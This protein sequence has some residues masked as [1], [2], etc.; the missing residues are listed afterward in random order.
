MRIDESLH[1]LEVKA[2]GDGFLGIAALRGD[3]GSVALFDAGLPGSL[4]SLRACL[5]E[6]GL[7]FEAV[8]RVFVTHH[9]FD[10]IG[11]IPELL[12]AAV[13]RKVLV[14]AHAEEV[15]YVQGERPPVKTEPAVRA[16][17]QANLPE[18]Q[19]LGAP[20]P[21]QDPPRIPVGTVLADGQHLDFAGGI[22][23]I[24]VPGHTPGHLCYYLHRSRVLVAGD[25]LLSD[26]G[27]LTP[28]T[29]IHSADIRRAYASLRKLD[30]FDIAAVVCYHGGYVAD[31]IRAQLR[32]LPA[33]YE[34]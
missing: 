23:A 26:G 6:A 15:P 8:D 24:H 5:E 28:P 22:T 2:W 1:M 21:L 30:A 10:H 3:D 32:A 4:P 17:M 20:R 12:A 11:G 16:R 34:P 19:V 7:P 25:A 29:P 9:D 27:R 18:G 33:E 13:P 31:D 14:L